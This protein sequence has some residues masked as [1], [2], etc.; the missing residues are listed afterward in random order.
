MGII[1]FKYKFL[2]I[3]LITFSIQLFGQENNLLNY[4]NHVV[5]KGET[6]YGIAKKYKVDLNSFF[7]FNPEAAEGIHKGDTLKI[8]ILANSNKKIEIIDADSTTKIHEVK[9]GETLWSIA[10][11]YGVK[12]EL[13]K[14]LNNLQKN[15]LNLDQKIILP[16][17]FSDTNDLVNPLFKTPN[18]PLLKP[19]DT[20]VIHK[21]KKKRNFIWYSFKL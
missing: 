16:N 4:N 11:F 5:L 19:C 17:T 13:I 1:K 14:N 8:P 18:H 2:F 21:V 15:E 12:V 9:Q 7:D 20:L 3:G 10:K 6:S